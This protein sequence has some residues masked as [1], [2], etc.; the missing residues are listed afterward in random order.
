MSR[1]TGYIPQHVLHVKDERRKTKT[2]DLKH[3]S[4]FQDKGYFP[5]AV[6]NFVALL[7]WHPGSTEEIFDLDGLT[8]AVSLLQPYTMMYGVINLIRI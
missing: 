3:T 6:V 2:D 7:G 1:T 8:K 4:L 5:E